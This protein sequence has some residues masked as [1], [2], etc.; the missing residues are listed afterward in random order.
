V[1]RVRLAGP[2]DAAAWLALRRGLWPEDRPGEHEHE[3]A[4]FFAGRA[5]EPMAVL[6]AED[7]A[8]RAVGMAEL[9]IR[10][11]AEGCRTNRVGYLEGWY[12]VPQARRTGVGR[13][14]VAG[15]QDWARRQGCAEIASDTE[16]SNRASRKAHEA[17][18][19][20]E[21]GRVVCF[22]KDL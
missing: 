2:E 10:P 7:A 11:H 4:E 17:I 18:G 12:V 16:T 6:L 8:G 9:S 1:S 15:A 19:F 13:A 3:I 21:A 5:V 14:L 20:E 22:R